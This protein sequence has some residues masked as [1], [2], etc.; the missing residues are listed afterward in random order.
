MDEEN[1]IYVS[2]DRVLF[3]LKKE[4]SSD[5]CYICQNMMNL[6]NIILSEIRIQNSIISPL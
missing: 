6:K 4:E 2:Y 1:A 5:P 3:S